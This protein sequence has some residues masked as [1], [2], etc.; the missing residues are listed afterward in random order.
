MKI[1]DCF[2]AFIEIIEFIFFIRAMQV[3]TVQTKTKKHNFAA[4]FFFTNL[5]ILDSWN[6]DKKRNKSQIGDVVN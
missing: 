4:K 3:I 1:G 2:Y 6:I 5:T